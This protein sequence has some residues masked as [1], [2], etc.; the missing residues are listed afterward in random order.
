MIS[1]AAME[2]A[3]AVVPS[4]GLIMPV[5]SLFQVIEFP[6]PCIQVIEFPDPLVKLLSSLI[7]SRGHLPLQ[8]YSTDDVP[9]P[10]N[11]N[12]KTKRDFLAGNGIRNW[13]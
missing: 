11:R 13:S 10:N 9:V 6:D 1:A 12:R 4:T 5:I 3:L 7:H 2:E 8:I